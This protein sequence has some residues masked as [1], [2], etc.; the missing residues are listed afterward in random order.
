MGGEVLEGVVELGD[1]RR[2][3]LAEADIV[4]GDDVE[5]SREQRDQI[6]EHEARGRE[7]VQEEQRRRLRI[8]RL[9]VE[10]LAAVDVG[11]AVVNG[12]EIYP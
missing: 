4:G 6:P 7:A 1:R 10:H 5:P 9:A 2:V 3:R 12:H 11:M 8:A